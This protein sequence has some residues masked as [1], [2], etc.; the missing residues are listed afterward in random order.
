MKIKSSAAGLL[1]AT[2]M[3]LAV[4]PTQAACYKNQPGWH[5][6]S[7][8]CGIKP[9]ANWQQYESG[10]YTPPVTGKSLLPSF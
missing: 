1:I 6:V 2:A 4:G 5:M 8:K 7:K 3:I 9:A 10:V